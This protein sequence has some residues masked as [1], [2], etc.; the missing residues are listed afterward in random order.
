MSHAETLRELSPKIFVILTP[1]RAR[2]PSNIYAKRYERHD[3]LYSTTEARRSFGKIISP[4]RTLAFQKPAA[5]E[6]RS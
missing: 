6:R 4:L 5:T 3:P 2:G 1:P